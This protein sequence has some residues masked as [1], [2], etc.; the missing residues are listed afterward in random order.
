[1]LINC[2]NC[3]KNCSLHS[4]KILDGKYT[5]WYMTCD[6]TPD[7]Y[8]RT[9]HYEDEKIISLKRELSQLR[10]EKAFKKYRTALR[11][12]RRYF[13]KIQEKVEAILTNGN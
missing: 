9:T 13:D 2:P 1:M 6:E 12:Y 5:R 10:Q 7:H 3:N 8:N 4:E 11:Q